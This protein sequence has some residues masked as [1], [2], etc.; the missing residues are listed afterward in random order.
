MRTVGCALEKL[1]KDPGQLGK[2]REAVAAT[3]KATIL[4]TELVNMHVRRILDQDPTADLSFCFGSNWLLN[5]YNEVT[6]GNGTPKI[7]ASLHLTCQE[8][9]PPFSP[10]SRSGILQCIKYDARNL[11]TVAATGRMDALPETDFSTRQACTG[12]GR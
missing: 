3:H 9:M 8:C 5:A 4:V 10:P 7:D 2:I 11:A 12:T 6:T 1:I